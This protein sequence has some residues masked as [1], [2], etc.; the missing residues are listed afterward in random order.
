MRL[1]QLLGIGSHTEPAIP[2]DN[3]GIVRDELLELFVLLG[4]WRG[5]RQ[6]YPQISGHEKRVLHV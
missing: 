2:D 3:A 4:F 5:Y 6:W 1:P